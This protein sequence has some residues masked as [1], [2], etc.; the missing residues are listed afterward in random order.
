MI[1]PNHFIGKQSGVPDQEES[2]F[3]EMAMERLGMINC[4]F[5]SFLTSRLSNR[6]MV[7]RSKGYGGYYWYS[8]ARRMDG[9]KLIDEMN[10][11]IKQLRANIRFIP[12]IFLIIL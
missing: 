8:S 7:A 6:R 1:A 12:I 5:L 10:R 4:L 2:A 11:S 3:E 9:V